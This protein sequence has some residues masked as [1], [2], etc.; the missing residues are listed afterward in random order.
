MFLEELEQKLTDNKALFIGEET[1]FRSAV[2]IPLVEEKGE[3]HVL[4]EMRAL[5]MRKQPGDS[6]FPGGR[7][8]T[9]DASPMHAALRETEEELG[10]N[11][12]TVNVIGELSPYIATPSFVVFPFVA[13]CDYHEIIHSYNKD[14]VEKV[15]TIP[16]SWLMEY[17]PTLHKVPVQPMPSPDFPFDKI[18]NGAQYRWAA[19]EQEEWFYEYENYIVWG[20]TARI[21]KYFID[22]MKK[23][24]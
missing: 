9:E 19:H 7:I 2:L 21:L 22:I 17:E 14:E 16:L 10:I 20:L 18:F 23:S 3:W 24:D 8:D 13:V 11:P 5:T 4:F 6:S 15:F 12:K 1:A